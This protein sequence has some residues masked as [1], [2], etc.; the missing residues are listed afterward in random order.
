MTAIPN[1]WMV[2]KIMFF[3]TVGTVAILLPIMAIPIAIFL[4]IRIIHRQNSEKER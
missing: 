3:S 4:I 2:I 1:I